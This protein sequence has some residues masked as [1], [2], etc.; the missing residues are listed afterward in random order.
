MAR[1]PFDDE[2]SD[3]IF[4]RNRGCITRPAIGQVEHS[5][6][7]FTPHGNDNFPFAITHAMVEAIRN[8]LGKNGS[9]RSCRADAYIGP[10]AVHLNTYIGTIVKP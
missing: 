10:I 3:S 4:A 7:T 9:D 5:A 1:N 2:Q 6:P 8:Q